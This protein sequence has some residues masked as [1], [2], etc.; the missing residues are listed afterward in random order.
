MVDFSEPSDG[1][2]L[3]QERVINLLNQLKMPLFEVSLVFQKHINQLLSSLVEFA[4]TT[5]QELPANIAYPWKIEDDDGHS[6]QQF[7]LDK[8]LERADHQRMDILDTLIRVTLIEIE[9]EMDNALLMIRQWE[10]LIRTQLSKV[11]SP[12]QLF[13]PLEIPEAW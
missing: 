13:S 10:H 12:G 9:I 1:M 5:G 6:A 7:S 11:Q 8:L 2:V 4:S 3:F